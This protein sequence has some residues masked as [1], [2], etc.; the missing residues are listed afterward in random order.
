VSGID[1]SA[2]TGVDR[3]IESKLM[4]ITSRSNHQQTQDLPLCA[5]NKKP[6]KE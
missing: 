1:A 6:E 4:L 2:K 3:R 5:A